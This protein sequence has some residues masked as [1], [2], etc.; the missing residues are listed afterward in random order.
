M[1]FEAHFKIIKLGLCS[2]LDSVHR[3]C[4]VCDDY[5]CYYLLN[6]NIDTLWFEFEFYVQI[7]KSTL[8]YPHCHISGITF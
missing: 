5:L 3:T 6:F 1:R 8:N 4:P 2:L 7:S